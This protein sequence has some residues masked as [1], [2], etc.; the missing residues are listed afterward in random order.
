MQ[1]SSQLILTSNVGLPHILVLIIIINIVIIV[2]FG[3]LNTVTHSCY[4]QIKQ[5]NEC[6]EIIFGNLIILIIPVCVKTFAV[7]VHLICI[8]LH[9]AVKERK[10]EKENE[11]K[12]ELE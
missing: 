4:I 10:R 12:G 5:K 1:N 2:T 7:A 3:I 6:A 8:L 9:D 11:S